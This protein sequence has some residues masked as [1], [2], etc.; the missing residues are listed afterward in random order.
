MRRPLLGIGLAAALLLA[1]CAGS[2]C[3]PPTADPALLPSM[4]ASGDYLGRQVQWGGLLVATRNLADR[5]ELD[6]VGYPLDRCGRPQMG[7]SPVGRFILVRPGYLEPT[8]FQSGRQVTASGKIVGVS[9]GR[10]GEA[11]Y[12]FPRLESPSPYLWPVQGDGGPF[13]WPTLG[14]GI[15]AGGIGIGGGVGISF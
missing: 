12:R 2:P 13:L 10:V 4:A 14:I 6:V 9:E 11:P 5:T 3:R 8:E 7:A 15:G 1:G